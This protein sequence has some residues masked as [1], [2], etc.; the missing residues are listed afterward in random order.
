MRSKSRP[1]VFNMARIALTLLLALAAC[2]SGRS[3]RGGMTG[4][5]DTAVRR[6]SEGVILMP[7]RNVA[8]TLDPRAL[9][10]V[11]QEL[12]APLATC[13]LERAIETME[14]GIVD[15]EATYVRVPEG[16]A[17]IRARL[18]SD[19]RVVRTELIESGFRDSVMEDCASMHIRRQQFPVPPQNS[20]TYVDVVYWVSLGFWA[21]ANSQESK[22]I[23][24]REQA[25]AGVRA[26]RCLRG[27]VGPGEYR[28]QGLN[29][30]GREGR[31]MI[32]RVSSEDADPE[33][34]ACVGQALKGVALPADRE[35]FVRPIE[36]EVSM[37]VAEDGSITVRD[38]EWLRVLELEQRAQREALREQLAVE[39]APPPAAD[40]EAPPPATPGVSL[41]A[42]AGP[43]AGAVVPSR[44]TPA[45]GASQ[46]APAVSSE[47]ATSASQL[48]PVESSEPPVTPGV[49]TSLD[50]GARPSQPVEPPSGESAPADPAPLQLVPRRGD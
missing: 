46:P 50:R 17:K 5:V 36:P 11:G 25:K 49:P 35:S 21:G 27:R 34:A 2:R 26:K 45:T 43:P 13:F 48:A 37:L 39:Q 32:N 30:V 33:I 15:G 44:T 23:V 42:A 38:E 4:G 24:R 14:L 31:T 22:G 7:S 20:P 9:A 3:A 47:P 19:G 28:F 8:T 1:G 41:G 12:R 10:V 16:Q 6:S 18:A 40:S 29:L